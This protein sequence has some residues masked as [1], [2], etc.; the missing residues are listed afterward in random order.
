MTFAEKLR[1]ELATVTVKP[2]CCRRALAE[3]LLLGAEIDGQR[4]IHV[5]YTQEAVAE[6]AVE[7]LSRQYGKAP[8][9]TQWGK[10]GHRYWDLS[11]SAPSCLKYL[12]SLDAEDA[13]VDSVFHFQCDACRSVFLRG[14]F[15]A[16]G[17]VSDPHKSFHLEFKLPHARMRLL[18]AFLTEMSYPARTVT[19]NGQAGIYYKDSS[20]IEELVTVMG[21]GT[22][23]FEIMNS[24]IEREIRNNE[25]RATNCVARNIEKTIAAAT[26]HIEAINKLMEAGKLES[27]PEAL[28]ETA[29]QRYANP[30]A[31]LDELV[32]IHVPSISKSGLN[33]RLQKIM[34]AADEI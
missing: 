34:E 21:S 3:G 8:E 9:V 7:I 5:R 16:V 11:L 32:A 28:Q 31:S 6:L 27:L 15:L 14:V 24:R 19:R 33:H 29:R 30:D 18:S 12:R 10:C 22:G 20:S 26:R 1:A 2:N 25:N 17:T 23:I 4:Q 13:C